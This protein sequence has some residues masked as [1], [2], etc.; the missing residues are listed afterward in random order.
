MMRALRR[1]LTLLFTL[2]TSL[3]LLAALVFAWGL[4]RRQQI[5]VQQQALVSAFASVSERLQSGSVVSDVWLAQ[6]EAQNRCVVYI[7]DNGSAFHFSGSWAPDTP[8]AELIARAKTVAEHAA[9]KG[10]F[11]YGTTLS[12]DVTGDCGD[13]YDAMAARFLARNESGSGVL[14]ILLRD[15]RG[16]QRELALLTVQY[17]FAW[18]AGTAALYGVSLLLVRRALR[19]T[20]E[21]WQRQREFVAAASHELRAPLAVIRAS[22]GEAR[23]SEGPEA[24]AFLQTADREAQRMASLAD[25]LLILASGDAGVRT[26]D[27]HEVETDTLCIRLYEMHLPLARSSGHPLTLSLPDDSLPAVRGDEHRLTQLF[28]ILLHNAFEHTPAGTPVELRALASGNAVRISVTD[29]GPGVPDAEKARV[30][31]RF[32]RSDTSRGGKA[33]F[34]LGLCVAHELAALHGARLTLTDAPGGGACFCVAFPVQHQGHSSLH[35]S[36]KSP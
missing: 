30:F 9:D 25:D 6:L 21:A 22:I 19:P 28:S 13:A 4:A 32:Y 33:H 31:E 15:R 10:E 16:G 5:L 36:Q 29:R 12:F 34:G 17:L 14:L 3:V 24:D 1:R 2:L 27:L 8:R 35:T 20:Y 26:A 18:L 7:E 11:S 23:S